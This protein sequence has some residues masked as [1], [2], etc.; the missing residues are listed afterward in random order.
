MRIVLENIATELQTELEAGLSGAGWEVS[1]ACTEPGKGTAQENAFARKSKGGGVEAVVFGTMGG[2]WQSRLAF[3][4]SL[5]PAP[6]LLALTADL[7]QLA[8]ALQEGVADAVL[9]PFLP[10]EVD[11]RIRA[12]LQQP[13]TLTLGDCELD[14]N[15][16]EARWPDRSFSLT[17]IELRLVVYLWRQ[18]GRP[19]EREELLRRVWG[20]QVAV[21]TR[22]VALTISRLRKK[23]EVVPDEPRHLLTAYGF[24]YRLVLTSEHG[25][26]SPRQAFELPVVR[27]SLVGRGPLLDAV[28]QHLDSSGRVLLHGQGGI[29]KTRV[30]LAL[31]TRRQVRQEVVYCDAS[32]Q[33]PESFLLTL[34]R[35]LNV[36]SQGA[37]LHALVEALRGRNLLLMLDNCEHLID[38]CSALLNAL[39]GLEG[40]QV[41]VTS[42][43]QFVTHL[44]HPI[45]V[46]PLN[47][48]DGCEL[49]L[50]RVQ[51]QTP[52]WQGT[53][54]DMVAIEEIVRR[55]DGL[56]LA[57]ELAAVR[58]PLLT[59]AQI[60]HR[61]EQRFTLLNAPH[62]MSLRPQSLQKTL[63]DAWEVLSPALQEALRSCAVFQGGFE[64]DAAEAILPPDA[65]PALDRVQLLV[66]HSLVQLRHGAG[67]PRC[68][69]FESVRAYLLRMGL[70]AESVERH[71]RHYAEV[72]NQLVQDA[73]GMEL[74]SAS[75]RFQV[76]HSNLQAAFQS[77][78]QT[79][80][81]QAVQIAEDMCQLYWM[82]G[83]VGALSLLDRLPTQ[84]PPRLARRVEVQRARALMGVGRVV[85]SQTLLEPL[86]QNAAEGLE[87]EYRLHA[88]QFWASMELEQG[89]VHQALE[90]QQQVV[91]EVEALGLKRWSMVNLV[92][93]ADCYRHAGRLKE[94]RDALQRAL[95]QARAQ[96]SQWNEMMALAHLSLVEHLLGELVQ[97]EQTLMPWLEFMQAVGDR[98]TELQGQLN[99]AQIRLDAG[100]L[101]DVAHALE[102][103]QVLERRAR[104]VSSRMYYARVRARLAIE[105]N[106]LGLAEEL[107]TKGISEFGAQRLRPLA[108][109]LGLLAWV[110][111]LRGQPGRALVPLLEAEKFFPTDAPSPEL[112]LLWLRR[113]MLLAALGEIDAAVQLWQRTALLLHGS[114]VPAHRAMVQLSAQYLMLEE[115]VPSQALGLS[116]LDSDCLRAL[117]ARAC[118]TDARWTLRL[119]EQPTGWKETAGSLY[120]HGTDTTLIQP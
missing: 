110:W 59:P 27:A 29:G 116:R 113:V 37:V 96:G 79:D 39:F 63:D 53:A 55:L 85:D 103:A 66:R 3:Y 90:M 14:L 33:T 52:L 67:Q 89:L 78:C 73:L 94:A 40:L 47:L 57:I 17:A 34:A 95:K 115:R 60:L 92:K 109:L 108:R 24:G 11:T 93:L 41:L 7:T 120:A 8:A 30:A 64:L 97:A 71:Q 32:S 87:P 20:Y 105:Q 22:A 62:P 106:E 4:R 102:R 77:A 26:T 65:L 5:T 74:Y 84:I 117:A 111:H 86:I 16:G 50:Q 70:P 99:L 88:L 6:L 76:E 13:A 56:P 46:P 61:L 49:F 38:P 25:E 23:I 54:H 81:V 118:W 12:R 83:D 98:Q 48:P 100:K 35:A 58:A 107:L 44:A 42:R 112:A 91:A 10:G 80:P 45:D 69:L 9:P 21:D 18:A 51:Q 1:V 19:V 28:E 31:G 75:R 43:I 114:E 72:L 15:A 104:D 2:P 36:R 119:F 101:E 82:Q 68:V